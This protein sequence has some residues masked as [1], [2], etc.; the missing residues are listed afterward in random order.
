MVNSLSCL[1]ILIFCSE[2]YFWLLVNEITEMLPKYTD[3]SS[4]VN[5]WKI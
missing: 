3:I 1:S 4:R 5:A 2:E